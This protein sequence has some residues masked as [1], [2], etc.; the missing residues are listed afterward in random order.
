MKDQSHQTYSS[1]TLTMKLDDRGL[2]RRAPS[3]HAHTVV[4]GNLPISRER[5]VEPRAT[6]PR[7]LNVYNAHPLNLY[8]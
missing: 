4:S 1:H 6:P 7:I 2:T 3:Y 8:L 5:R